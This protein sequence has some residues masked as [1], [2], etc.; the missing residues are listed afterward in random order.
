MILNP[1]DNDS[2]NVTLVTRDDQS[3]FTYR[4]LERN[5]SS[6]NKGK[7]CNCEQC[8]SF[9]SRKTNL[10]QNIG[11]RFFC[12]ICET[13]AKTKQNLRLHTKVTR[14]F[15]SWGCLS[16]YLCSNTQDAAKCEVFSCDVCDEKTLL[17]ES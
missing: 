8:D 16:S 2:N 4:Y 10:N 17:L 1:I 12:N 7:G 9:Y 14:N 13:N 5:N 3:N 15:Q 11:F 6:K